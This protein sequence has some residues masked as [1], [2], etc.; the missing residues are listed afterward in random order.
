MLLD[1]G[2]DLG[3]E[4][5]VLCLTAPATYPLA[6]RA[7]PARS[8]DFSLASKSRK[9]EVQSPES[10][11]AS[12]FGRR[13]ADS[14]SNNMATRFAPP[15]SIAAAG[16]HTVVAN[17]SVNR[18]SYSYDKVGNRLGAAE[19]NG[20]RTTW[21]YD[22]SYQLLQEHRSGLSGFNVSRTA[23]TALSNRVLRLESRT[24]HHRHLR[25]RR[26]SLER[27]PTANGSAPVTPMMLAGNRTQQSA[28]TGISF[29]AWDALNRLAVSGTARRGISGVSSFFS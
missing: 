19:S 22:P 11:N 25:C 12:L 23:T 6:A 28:P 29:Y 24:S 1:R 4:L 5:N 2:L 20:D 8:L 15:T 9:T 17:G 13:W 27:D 21:S 3:E 7:N 26:T 18:F 10:R 14:R 16:H